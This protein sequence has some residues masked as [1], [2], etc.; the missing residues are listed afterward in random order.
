MRRESETGEE[1]AVT[2]SE[3]ANVGDLS[4]NGGK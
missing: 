3:E 4:G 1:T 2:W